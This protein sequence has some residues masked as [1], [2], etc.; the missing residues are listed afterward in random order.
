LL[1]PLQ[2][3]PDAGLKLGIVRSCGHEHADPSHGRRLLRTC[4]ERPRSGHAAE[5]RDELAPFHCEL[6]LQLFQSSTSHT[7]HPTNC[8]PPSVN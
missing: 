3:R 6:A 2:K 5:K 7:Q 4:R 1:Q 8:S